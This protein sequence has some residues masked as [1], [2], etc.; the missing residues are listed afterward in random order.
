MEPAPEEKIEPMEVSQMDWQ[1]PSLAKQLKSDILHSRCQPKLKAVDQR[2]PRATSERSFMQR[3]VNEVIEQH[4][5]K[6]KLSCLVLAS[7]SSIVEE[8]QQ[9]LHLQRRDQQRVKWMKEN[10]VDLTSCTSPEDFYQKNVVVSKGDAASLE[11][12]T[13]QQAQCPER[14]SARRL[15]LTATLCKAIATRRKEDVSAL[16][17]RKLNSKFFVN[18][19][20]EYGLRHEEEAIN[21]YVA[22]MQSEDPTISVRCWGLVV[23][24][25]DPWLACSPDAI[26]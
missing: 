3:R 23:S 12:R 25:A 4:L 6:G 24:V 17:Q 15:R 18:T 21:D 9:Q 1:K 5:Q 14:F 26:I 7:G 8:R 20:T 13:R 19:A 11:I 2:Y 22:M 10:F 16:L